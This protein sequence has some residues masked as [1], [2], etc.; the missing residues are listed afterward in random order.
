M[1]EPVRVDDACVVAVLE[2]HLEKAG[3]L[4]E[5]QGLPGRDRSAVL[6]SGH[7]GLNQFISPPK[8][9]IR[10]ILSP[11]ATI[12]SVFSSTTDLPCHMLSLGWGKFTP[13]R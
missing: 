6:C 3:I 1:R 10:F 12:I 9:P 13:R 5:P 11:A 7:S 2:E 4:D 8:L